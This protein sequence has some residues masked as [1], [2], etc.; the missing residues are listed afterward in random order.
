[1]V[2]GL[3][4]RNTFY[5]YYLVDIFIVHEISLRPFIVNTIIVFMINAKTQNIFYSS[6][7]IGIVLNLKTNSTNFLIFYE[8]STSTK[9]F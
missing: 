8:N 4:I 6:I 1:M 7:V 5:W 2:I 3:F 9:H